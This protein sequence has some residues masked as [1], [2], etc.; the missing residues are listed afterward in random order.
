MRIDVKV[1]GDLGI[2]AT[3][4]LRAMLAKPV[5]G[6]FSKKRVC[7]LKPDDSVSVLGEAFYLV[8]SSCSWA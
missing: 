5:G 2:K 3:T 8:L 4:K 1:F 6:V 7:G